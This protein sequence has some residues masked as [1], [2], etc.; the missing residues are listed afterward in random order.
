MYRDQQSPHAVRVTPSRLHGAVAPGAKGRAR[1]IDWFRRW[2]RP[3]RNM[4]A[5]K[6]CVPCAEVEDLAQEVFLR[7]LRYS[8]D[9]LVENPQAYFSRIATNVVLEWRQRCRVRMPHEDSWLEELQIDA[10]ME[11]E[12]E[13]ARISAKRCLRAAVDQLP[14]RQRELL[15]LHVEEGL[16]YKQIAQAR[17]LTYRIVLR[18][19]TRAYGNLRRHVVVEDL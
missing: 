4:I 18:D 8:D 7:L 15:L 3:V 5:A 9:V 10:A 11:P 17:N 1:F 19:L 13:T 2:R 12:N 6:S 14:A 16:T